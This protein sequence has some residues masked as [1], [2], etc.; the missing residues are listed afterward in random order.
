VVSYL[1]GR[2]VGVN[3]KQSP[4]AILACSAPLPPFPPGATHAC[5]H[6]ADV[7]DSREV[8]PSPL[9]AQAGTCPAGGELGLRASVEL[10]GATSAQDETRLPFVGLDDR[11]AVRE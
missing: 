8:Q 4:C 5:D 11:L 2:P 3:A 1:R 6:C 7:V 9:R 10:A